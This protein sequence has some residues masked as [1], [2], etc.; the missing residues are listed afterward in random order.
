MIIDVILDHLEEI[1]ERDTGA[2]TTLTASEIEWL[3]RYDFEHINKVFDTEYETPEAKDY[4]LKR[5]FIRYIVE[6]DYNIEIIPRILKVK[7]I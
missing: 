3:R 2:S 1:E 6:Q 7:W 4:Y 5:E